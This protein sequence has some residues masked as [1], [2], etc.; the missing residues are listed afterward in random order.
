MIKKISKLALGTMLIGSML[1]A[2]AMTHFHYDYG[3]SGLNTYAEAWFHG[4]IKTTS[5][6]KVSGQVTGKYVKQVKVW[7]KEGDRSDIDYSSKASN[8][9]DSTFRDAY[10]SLFNDPRYTAKAGKTWYY[11]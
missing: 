3:R 11:Q 10:A 8:K 4:N 5:S 7:V 9:N 2:S 6:N 1:S